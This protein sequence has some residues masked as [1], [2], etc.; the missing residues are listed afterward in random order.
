MQAG[1][2]QRRK[3]FVG[4]SKIE[5]TNPKT[6]DLPVMP[7]RDY[8]VDLLKTIAII[9]V[10]IIHS[11]TGWS[12]YRVGSVNWISN[13]FWGSISRASVPIFLMC[14]GALFLSPQ[15]ELSLKKLYQKKLLRIVVAMLFWGMAYKIFHL[16][17]SGNLSFEGIYKAMK[18]VLLFKQEFHLYYL[19]IIIFVYIF[20]PITQVFVK[21]ATSEQMLYFLAVWFVF[22]IIYPTVDS[23]WPINLISGIP[24][25]WLL[26][27]TYASIGYGVLGYYIKNFSKPNLKRNIAFLSVG[28]IIVFSGTWYFTLLEGEFYQNFLESMSVGVA[29]MA[30]GIFGLVTSVRI[31]ASKKYAR[32]ITYIS[33]ASFCIYLVHVFFI[34]ML[35]KFG[36]TINV[37][38]SILSI[39]VIA[40]IIFICSLGVYAVLSHIRIIKKWLI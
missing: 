13:L 23:F 19:H 10:M 1:C 29:L 32:V 38:P 37:F 2:L 24:K 40:I 17:G 5:T 14:S 16:A 8:S 31:D 39:P 28:L 9:G 11:C 18:E 34:S 36:L 15:K 26:N 22:G 12:L 21:N 30:I 6:E 33:K 20:L 35:N 7:D 4:V 27:M 3:Y 25:Q